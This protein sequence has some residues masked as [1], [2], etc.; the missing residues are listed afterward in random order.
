M[1]VQF[2]ACGAVTL[3]S[4]GV[5]AGFSLAGLAGPDRS[6]RFARYAASRSVALLIALAVAW[7]LL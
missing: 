7:L 6:D 1:T 4:A 2:W 3:L 5:S